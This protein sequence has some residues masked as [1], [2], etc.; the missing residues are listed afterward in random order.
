MQNIEVSLICTLKNEKHSIKELLDSLL[1]QS[2]P[3]DE[4]I[5]VDGGSI[6]GTIDVIK[7]YIKKGNSIKLI[8][9]NGVNIAEGRNIAIKN[10]KYAIIASTDAGCRIDAYWLE[11][12]I[13]PFEMDPSVDVVSGWYEADAR[14]DFE[15]CV[16]ELTYPKLGRVIKNSDKFLP[17]SRSIAYKK[18]S[19][20][21]VKGYPE[22]LYTA[23]DTLFDLNLRNIGS[24]IVFAKDAVV[25]WKPRSNIKEV[26]RQFYLY[27]RG[28]GHA[29]LYYNL[30]NYIPY[31]LGLVLLLSGFIYTF[32]WIL[33]FA[34]ILYYLLMPTI[35]V[36]K[37]LKSKKAVVLIPLIRVC[38]DFG[39]MFGYM[40]GL[41]Q[42]LKKRGDLEK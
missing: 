33:L 38:V 15:Q 29:E 22:W 28:N 3:P 2:R 10:A 5:I 8:V 13:K 11:N 16:A 4:I 40:I 36:Y 9:K 39:N 1:S 24:K 31:A 27:S 35:S 6:D 25:Y 20:E 41:I 32:L 18:E 12:L 37:R 21:K 17:S 14:T 23:E 34:C 26:F 30:L 19:W 42:G 7:S